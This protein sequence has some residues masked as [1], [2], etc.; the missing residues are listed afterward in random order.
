M[1]TPHIPLDLLRG[2]IRALPRPDD[3]EEWQHERI[4]GAVGAVAGMQPRDVVEAMLAVQAIATHAAVM[5]TYRLALTEQVADEAARRQRMTATALIRCM[6][7]TLRLLQQRQA[8]PIVVVA[9]A[10]PIP[11]VDDAELQAPPRPR[12]EPMHRETVAPRAAPAYTPPAFT[13]Y[14]SPRVVDLMTPA[15]RRAFYGY[16]EEANDAAVAR[17]AAKEDG[18]GSSGK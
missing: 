16:P 13:P 11:Q 17:L 15:E 14:V 8:A 4:A 6:G 10:L 7:D 9:G 18:S 12:Q 2:L 1:S 3:G 5:E